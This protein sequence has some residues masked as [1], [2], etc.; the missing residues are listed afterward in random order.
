MKTIII[1]L[2]VLFI[3]YEILKLISLPTY[4]RLSLERSKYLAL[5]IVETLYLFYVVF[6]A[7][8]GFWYVGLCVLIVSVITAFQIMDDVIEK[9]NFNKKIRKHLFADGVV[10]IVFLSFIIIKELLK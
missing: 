4:W 5:V 9:T 8:V 2:T 6:L 7:F 3:A 10:S 1:Y